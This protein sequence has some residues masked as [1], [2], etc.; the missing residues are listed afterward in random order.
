MDSAN[1][2]TMSDELHDSRL[3]RLI[4]LNRRASSSIDQSRRA[5]RAFSDDRESRAESSRAARAAGRSNGRPLF[6][7]GA[8]IAFGGTCN[9]ARI[10]AASTTCRDHVPP[11]GPATSAATSRP[12]CALSKQPPSAIAPSDPITN[13]QE[14]GVQRC[15]VSRCRSGGIPRVRVPETRYR[16][17]RSA[18]AQWLPY[19]PHGA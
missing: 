14:H 16:L 17:H 13:Y 7:E 9:S 1:E 10:T 15:R 18:R 2:I 12:L 3:M 11:A 4:R 6:V 5:V 19:F 8:I